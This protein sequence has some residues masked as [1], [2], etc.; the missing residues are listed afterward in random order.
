VQTWRATI[1][2]VVSD[3]YGRILKRAKAL[4]Q[5]GARLRLHRAVMTNEYAAKRGQVCAAAV[6]ATELRADHGFAEAF[7]HAIDMQPSAPMGHLH[8]PRRRGDRAEI[9][10]QL[11]KIVFEQAHLSRPERARGPGKVRSLSRAITVNL[12]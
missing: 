8:R 6:P 7:M 2:D 9:G 11:H 3:L 10:N 1:A 12:S 5:S 4:G